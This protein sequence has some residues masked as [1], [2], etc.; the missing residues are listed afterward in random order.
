M[1]AVLIGK[2]IALSDLV[3]KLE[4]SYTNNLKA[5]LRFLEQREANSPKK[6]R[7]QEIV[8]LWAKNK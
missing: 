7:R 3:K 5:H 4:K 2:S 1:K 8:K 6:S